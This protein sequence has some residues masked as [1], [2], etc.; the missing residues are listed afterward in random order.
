MG[1]HQFHQ[2]YFFIRGKGTSIP[3]VQVV[4]KIIMDLNYFRAI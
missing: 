3:P 4:K 1:Y 2:T